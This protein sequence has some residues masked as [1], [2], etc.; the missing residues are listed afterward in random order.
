MVGSG[1]AAAPQARSS[2]NATPAPAA[3]SSSSSCFLHADPRRL[4]P[5]ARH[6]SHLDRCLISV[7]FL[8]NWCQRRAVA[9]AGGVRGCATSPPFLCVCMRQPRLWPRSLVAR[10][11]QPAKRAQKFDLSRSEGRAC[12]GR[13]VHRSDRAARKE[14]ALRCSAVCSSTPQLLQRRWRRRTMALFLRPARRSATLQPSFWQPCSIW[15]WSQAG[16]GA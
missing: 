8:Y 1:K 5:L 11:L 13:P 9:C 7:C 12:A 10:A 4:C 16:K 6:R 2:C 3:C 15:H 14:R